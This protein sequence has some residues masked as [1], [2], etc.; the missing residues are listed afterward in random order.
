MDQVVRIKEG[1][2]EAVPVKLKRLVFASANQ[3]RPGEST[4]A[5]KKAKLMID[6]CRLTIDDW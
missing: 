2:P 3:K 6:D 5:A 4:T 1:E